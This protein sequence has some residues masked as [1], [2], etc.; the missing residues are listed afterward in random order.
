MRKLSKVVPAPETRTSS[1]V[2]AH[3]TQ[4]PPEFTV[5]DG[6]EVTLWA[7]NPLLFKPTQMN[8]DSKGRLWVTSAET[9]PQVEVGQTANDKILV[10]EDRDGDGKAEKSTPFATGLLMPTGVLPGDDGCYV[11]QSTDLLH[12]RDT[13]GDGK[14][15]EKRR[16]LSGFGTEDTHH[17]LHTLR[18]GPDG[19]IWMNQSI[20]TRS[21]A[22]TP[23]GVMRLKSGGVMRFDP[24]TDKLETVFYGWCNPWGHQFDRYGQSFMTDG[25][26]GGGINWGVP[27]AMYF[28]YANAPKT[29][30]SISP[31]SYPKFCGL[32]VIESPHFP[33]DWQGSMITCDFRAHR[34]VRFAVSEQGSGYAAQEAG[35]IVRTNSV[36]FR[37]IDVKIGPDGALYIADW[38]NPIINHG[39]V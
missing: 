37:P 13:N 10:L 38:S 24:R 27:D 21:D 39:E 16:V 20:Y 34:V 23:F 6:Y 7:E 9:Y 15:D 18:R 35:D 25:A 31:G 33:D 22:E 5:A 28:T 30:D 14:A 4:P 17:N 2:A 26:G 11:A 19:K 32:E 1:A 8:F 36:N 29:L 3:T 12:F